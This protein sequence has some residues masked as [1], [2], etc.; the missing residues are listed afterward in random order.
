MPAR[1]RSPGTSPP[2]ESV[3]FLLIPGFALMSYAAAVEPLRVANQLSGKKL[4]RWWN[5]VPGDKPAIASNGAAVMPDFK[6]GSEVASLDL[7]LVCAGGNPAAFNDRRTFSWLRKLASRGVNIGGISG[8]PVVLANAGLLNGRRCTAHWEHIPGLQ[9]SFPDIQ[10]TRALFEL[11]GNRI[12][13]SGGAAG[14]DMMVA[15]ITRDHGYELATAVSDWLLHTHVREGSGPQ[16][17]DLKFRLGVADDRLLK[18]LKAMEANL[19]MPLSRERLANIAG[20]SLRQL[21]R[22]FKSQLGR[23]ASEH[24]ITLRLARSRQLL[25]ETTLPILEIAV[26]TGFASASQFSRSFKRTFGLR[27]REARQLDR[28]QRSHPIGRRLARV[29]TI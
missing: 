5:A 12:T 6:F 28:P 7:I 21:E 23:G 20:V 11:S 22:S 8:G 24:Y 3:G 19:E 18:A 10:I 26:A 14:L 29:N 16:R 27:P 2:I 17:M 9:E 1:N 4:Y 25:R 15:L 13:C